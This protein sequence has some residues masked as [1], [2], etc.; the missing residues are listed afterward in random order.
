MRIRNRCYRGFTL[1]ELLVV[2]AIIGVLVGLLLPAVQAAREAARRMQCSNNLKQI[3]LA[4]HNYA[5]AHKRFPPGEVGLSTDP[6][7]TSTIIPG[8]GGDYKAFG[9][10]RE[11]QWVWSVLVMPYIEQGNMYS[12]LQGLN[13]PACPT[14]TAATPTP[15]NG[16]TTWGP[17]LQQT[18]PTYVCPSDPGEAVNS[19]ADGY[20]KMNYV[21]SKN[22]A[23]VNTSWS[24][25]DVTDGTSN[26]F[27]CAE[28]M[29][30]AKP[31]NHWGGVWSGRHRSNGSYSFDDVPPPN[32]PMPAGVINAT[33]G[34]CCVTAQDRVPGT[35]INLNTRGGASSAHTGGMQTVFVDGSVHFISNNIQAYYPSATPPTTNVYMSLWGKNEGAVVGD[36]GQ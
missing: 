9:T 31:V 24:F 13:L 16:A 10:S 2:I 5:D 15:P 20:G 17:F 27:L 3:G 32:T 12:V 21:V 30:G 8:V 36:W 6:A 7:N 22:M 25:K 4:F 29:L 14:R 35:T 28:R 1:V 33:T 11:N 18:I 19:R 23:F 26:T 34:L